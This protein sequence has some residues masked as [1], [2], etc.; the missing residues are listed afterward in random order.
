[1]SKATKWTIGLL[2]I[3]AIDL[4]IL[5]ALAATISYPYLSI[6]HSVSEIKISTLDFTTSPVGNEGIFPIYQTETAMP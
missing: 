3:I 6:L 1:M 4:C 5:V 2:A